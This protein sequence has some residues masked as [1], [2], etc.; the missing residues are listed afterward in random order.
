LA[1]SFGCLTGCFN[2]I[3]KKICPVSLLRFRAPL[4]LNQNTAVLV[5][6]TRGQV[7][8]MRPFPAAALSSQFI[9]RRS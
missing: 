1:T 6:M 2:T 3:D 5:S 9:A 7:G 4:P 8:L